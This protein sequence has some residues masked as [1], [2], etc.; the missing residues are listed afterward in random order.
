VKIMVLIDTS[1]EELSNLNLYSVR[2]LWKIVC[3]II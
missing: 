1:G 3:L 2:D